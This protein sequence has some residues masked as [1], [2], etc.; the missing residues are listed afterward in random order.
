VG[1][2]P[3]GYHDGLI[4][5]TEAGDGSISIV[6]LKRLW[7]YGNYT[8]FVRPGFTRVDVSGNDDLYPVAFKG[9]RNGQEQLILVLINDKYT[10]QAAVLEGDFGAYKTM[11]IHETSNYRDLAR[12][13]NGAVKTEFTVP[14]QSVV[15]IVLTK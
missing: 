9:V 1:V 4:Y 5:A 2:A 13:Y 7:A 3:G 11:Q 10:S 14:M 12:T 15:T 6:P 8:R